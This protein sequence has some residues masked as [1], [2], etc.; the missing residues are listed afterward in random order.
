M[1]MTQMPINAASRGG[2]RLLESPQR[3]HA[4]VLA[5]FPGLDTAQDRVL[6][7]VDHK[8]AYDVVLYVVSP[9]KPDFN[10]IVEQAGWQTRLD[11]TWK[12]A[13][14]RPFLARLESGQSWGFRLRANTVSRSR[15]DGSRR[16]HTR[17]L[18]TLSDRVQWLTSR[19]ERLGFVIP[20]DNDPQ[21]P[22][23]QVSI[24]NSD[25]HNFQRANATD[26]GRNVTIAST[27]F[28]GLLTVTD[29][30]AFRQTLTKGVGRA[31]A[32]GCGLMT[33]ANAGR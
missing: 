23:P 2:R 27:Q 32:Y 26:G 12:T 16:I 9:Q 3:M 17:T 22:Q 8:S 18:T 24:S 14:Y 13:D 15:P 33:L 21:S 19:S 25:K 30:E 4:A 6:W 10:H 29:P 1:F 5:G 28:E 7:R 31:K 11:V 20:F